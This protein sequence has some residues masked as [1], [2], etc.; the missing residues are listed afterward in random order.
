MVK[1]LILTVS[2]IIHLTTGDYTPGTAGKYF[3]YAMIKVQW[4]GA[5][6][7]GQYIAIYTKWKFI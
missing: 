5:A 2:T 7:N 6:G 3:I 4:G 1:F